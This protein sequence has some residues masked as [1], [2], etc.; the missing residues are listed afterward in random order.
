MKEQIKEYMINK[1]GHFPQDLDQLT[2]FIKGYLSLA[3]SVTDEEII[4][5]LLNAIDTLGT[6]SPNY[7]MV[8]EA[9]RNANNILNNHLPSKGDEQPNFTEKGVNYFDDDNTSRC[10]LCHREFN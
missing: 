3:P 5:D 7:D 8:N 4:S 1:F 2:E 9:V 10:K 6:N